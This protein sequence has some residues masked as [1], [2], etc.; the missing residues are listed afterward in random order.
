MSTENEI[1]N[2]E[3]ITRIDEKKKD[4]KRNKKNLFIYEW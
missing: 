1:K 2:E 3:T 4:K